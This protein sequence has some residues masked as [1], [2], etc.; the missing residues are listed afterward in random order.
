MNGYSYVSTHLCASTE[1]FHGLV[2]VFFEDFIVSLRLLQKCSLAFLRNDSMDSIIRLAIAGI[3]LNHRDANIS[4]MKFLV[5]LMKCSYIEQVMY[6]YR[7]GSAS[8]EEVLVYFYRTSTIEHK[9][10]NFWTVPARCSLL[11]RMYLKRCLTFRNFVSDSL[12]FLRKMQFK[13]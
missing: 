7:T 11:G 13:I 6:P 1:Y 10:S 12:W 9:S 8:L 5:E 4:I 3:T 2:F